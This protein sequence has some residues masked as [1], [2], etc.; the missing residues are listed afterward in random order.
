MNLEQQLEHLAQTVY[1]KQVDVVDA[2]MAQVRQR[3]YLVLQHRRTLGRRI[4]LSA[5]AA[6]AVAIIAVPALMNRTFNEEQIG[7]MMAS[8][9]DYDYYSHVESAVANPIEYLYEEPE[10]DIE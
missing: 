10:P 5:A 7:S 1:P 3:P 8:V 9:Q 4:A 6:V 2:V